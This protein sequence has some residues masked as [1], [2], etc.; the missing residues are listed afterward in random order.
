[1]GELLLFC[2]LL[3][4]FVQNKMQYPY[5]VPIYIYIYIYNYQRGYKNK[6][7]LNLSKY[8]HKKY[9]LHF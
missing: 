4:G 9:D 6:F 2:R 7:L 8:Y 3:L 5:A 1:M